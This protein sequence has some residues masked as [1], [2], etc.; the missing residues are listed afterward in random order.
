MNIRLYNAKILTMETD[1]PIFAGEVWVKDERIAFVG[2]E[3]EARWQE[4]QQAKKQVSGANKINTN[5]DQ[6]IDC[7]GNLLMPGFKNAHT[8]SAMT[9]LR[10]YADD[11][12]LQEWLHEKVFPAEAK[13]TAEDIYELTKLAILE[14]LTSGITSIF[15]MYINPDAVGNAC[16]DMGMR[17]VLVS[18]LNNFTSSVK[19]TEEEYK[20]WNA[21]K[22]LVS[23]R[24]GFHA[25]YTTS[26]EVLEKLSGLA[27]ELKASVYAHMNETAKE[28]AECKERYG[29]EPIVFL[30]SLGMFDYGGG[31]FHCVH[32]T[33]KEVEIMKKRG[34]YVVTNPASNLKLASGIA[35]IKGYVQEG[36]PVAIG[37]DGPA[38]NNCL[39]MFREMYLVSALA[40]L[41]EEDAACMDAVEVLHMATVNGAQ[42]MGLTDADILKEGKLADIIMI[43]LQQP[44]MQPLH[45]ISKNLVY[46]GSKANVLMTMINGKI[47]YKDGVFF[48]FESAS[49][50]YERANVIV[51]RTL[52]Q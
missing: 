47:L 2:T 11:L 43:D 41:R 38:S 24:L 32:V 17:C 10:S 23:Y 20:R 3:A 8:H 52:L 49:D 34:M 35:P 22:G 27:H 50:I 6:E 19:Q 4:Q 42:A 12:P 29:M 44:N 9:F 16:Q 37:T 1:K 31:G 40:K 25:E 18:G 13:L 39:D 21:Q 14:Y 48:T 33:D 45:N 15:D 36:I 26:R 46:S 30:D 51:K 5:W 28:V 7:H